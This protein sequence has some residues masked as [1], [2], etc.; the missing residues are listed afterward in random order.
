MALNMDCDNGRQ[1]H[2]PLLPDLARNL[3]LAFAGI[4]YLFLMG[5]V[6]FV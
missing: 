5:V 4:A 6:L 3:P 1:A 2:H